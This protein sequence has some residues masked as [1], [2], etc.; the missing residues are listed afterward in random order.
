MSP[1]GHPACTSRC[2]LEEL[3]SA[4]LVPVQLLYR[5]SSQSH[6]FYLK[7]DPFVFKFFPPPSNTGNSPALPP[8]PSLPACSCCI[9]PPTPVLTQTLPRL[10]GPLFSLLASAFSVIPFPSLI[11]ASNRLPKILGCMES[12]YLTHK[13]YFP[14][15]AP[16]RCL[17]HR[18]SESCFHLTLFRLF[19][20]LGMT[21]LC[22]QNPT[23]ALKNCLKALS[24]G[25]SFP[26]PELP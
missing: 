3:N 17:I 5:T 11:P 23:Q 25:K 24:P 21:F 2:M 1:Y 14:D 7:S 15:N 19:H 9:I 26:I 6:D 18:L 12:K 10:P 8:P 20:Q 4:S 22:C 16:D 13:C